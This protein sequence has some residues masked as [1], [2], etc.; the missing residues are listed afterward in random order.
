MPIY[1][2]MIILLLRQKGLFGFYLII[3]TYKK[4]M[5]NVKLKMI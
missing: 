1:N 2:P 3:R 4:I 5:E